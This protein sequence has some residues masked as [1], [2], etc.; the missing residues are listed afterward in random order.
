MKKRLMALLAAVMALFSVLLAGCGSE[1]D[2]A[3]KV[4][5]NVLNWGDYI[6]ESLI[7]QFEAQYNIHINYIPASSNEEMYVSITTEGSDYDIVFPSDYLVE[8]LISEG[9]LQKIDYGKLPN[10]QYLDEKFMNRG[11]AD[12]DPG[13]VYS[14]PYTWGTLGILYNTKYVTKPVTS[15]DI[16]WD[17]DYAGEI[18]MYDS[19]RDSISAALLRLGYDINTRDK[20]QIAEAVETL[21]EQKPLVKSNGGD[22]MRDSMIGGSGAL[23]LTY[24]GDAVYCMQANP[25][26]AFAVPE[27]GSNIF[28]DCMVILDTCD[29]ADAAHQFINFLLD[30]EVATI[31]SEYIGYST[32]NAKVM[33]LIDPEYLANNAFNPSDDV[34]SRCT[35][36][37]DLGDFTQVYS[38]AWQEVKWYNP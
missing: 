16:L 17:A 14:V 27:E 13:N 18:Y 12:Y 25:D 37:H 24:S 22:E 2:S 36:F 32:P 8:R 21:K 3:A 28:F 26:L 31:N 15:W 1:G 4:T 29:A 34:I 35:V 19:M 23:C 33:E 38:D 11:E 9:R 7:G 6:E 20:A 10:A 30:P 5:L